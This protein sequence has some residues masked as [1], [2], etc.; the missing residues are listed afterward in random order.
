MSLPAHHLS[1]QISG[2]ALN[3]AGTSVP[4]MAQQNGNS[5]PGQMQNPNIHRG[6]PYMDPEFVKA[7]RY[8]MEKM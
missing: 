4:G 1:G 5:L 8:M 6:V 2:Q 3:Q 7:R